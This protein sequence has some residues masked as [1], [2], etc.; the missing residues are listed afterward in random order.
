MIF[1]GVVLS[2]RHAPYKSEFDE[3]NHGEVA[4]QSEILC[5]LDDHNKISCRFNSS[6]EL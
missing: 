5:Q 1:R 3:H 4:E 2:N 6:H